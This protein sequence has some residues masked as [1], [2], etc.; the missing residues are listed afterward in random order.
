[1]NSQSLLDRWASVEGGAQLQ[2]AGGIFAFDC[3]KTLIDGDIGEATLRLAL[4]RRWVISHEA[5]WKHL[6]DAELGSPRERSEW[7]TWYE[8]GDQE[9]SSKTKEDGL[10]QV[11]WS[12]Y[13]ELCEK[14][15]HSAYVYA[16][17]LAYGRSPVEVA[18]L[19]QEALEIDPLV[20]IRPIIK[21]LVNK[22][23]HLGGD[24]WV[25]SS[26]QVDIVRVI[27]SHYG[28]T[29]KNVI[30]IDFDRDPRSL[31]SGDQLSEP[32]PIGPL[33]VDALRAQT[34]APIRMMAGDS[35]HDLYLMAEATRGLFIDHGSDEELQREAS[36]L[37]AL[38]V[39][40]K[41]LSGFSS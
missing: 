19:A 11:L 36:S 5:W 6:D 27:A 14:D 7:R 10:A 35:R 33:K 39:S 4:R 15:I 40:S 16:A 20:Q 41:S 3:D 17:R 29:S 1:M 26:S 2:P 23:R 32:A 37:G 13:E 25:V 21:D 31:V 34:Q 18:L 24:A 22:I 30:G 8:R 12:A 28:I 9:T 38:I